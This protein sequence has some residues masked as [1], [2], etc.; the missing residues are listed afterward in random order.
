MYGINILYLFSLLKKQILQ[1]KFWWESAIFTDIEEWFNSD[2][3][4]VV[5]FILNI[6]NSK[7]HFYEI[8]QLHVI[9]QFN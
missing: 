1:Y 8:G 6:H 7:K 2:E 9:R 3:M 5:M 4:K